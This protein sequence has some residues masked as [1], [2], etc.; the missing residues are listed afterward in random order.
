MTS[1]FQNEKLS[2]SRFKSEMCNRP[3]LPIDYVIDYLF[4][5]GNRNRNRLFSAKTNRYGNRNRHEKS[6]S[7][8]K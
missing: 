4:F 5:E 3:R 6:L 2:F 8:F 1:I 7:R